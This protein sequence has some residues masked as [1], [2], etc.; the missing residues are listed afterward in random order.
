M[1]DTCAIVSRLLFVPASE[2]YTQAG[3]YVPS[4]VLTYS[5]AGT[6]AYIRSSLI[7]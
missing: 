1:T 3:K 2:V 5:F 7:Y 6:F 4:V